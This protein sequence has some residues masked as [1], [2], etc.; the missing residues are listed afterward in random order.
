MK[1]MDVNEAICNRRSVRCYANRPISEEQILKLIYLAGQAPS[2]KNRQPWFF[3]VINDQKI[4]KEFIDMLS[5][6]ID[7]LYRRCQQKNIQRPDILN[8]KNSLRAME[9]A[10][11]LILVKL[12]SRYDVCHD[13]GVD[14]QLQALDIEATDLLSIGAAIQNILLAAKE[15]GLGSL[16]VCDIF[17]AYPALV[18]FL[19]ED[20]PIVSAICLGYPG[21]ANAPRPRRPIN[22]IFTILRKKGE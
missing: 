3:Y 17:Y 7:L 16:W 9:Q 18:Q 6:G 11:A 12:V 22:E 10:A 1:S 15:M 21:E 20:K 19:H 4:Q 14:W 5:D 2:A 13:D 8:A